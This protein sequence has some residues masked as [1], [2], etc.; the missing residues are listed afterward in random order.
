MPEENVEDTDTEDTEDTEEGKDT[1]VTEKEDSSSSGEKKEEDNSEAKAKDGGTDKAAKE[2]SKAPEKYDDFKMPEDFKVNEK[3]IGDFQPLAK[4]L[5]LTQ[6]NAQK[7]ID[8]WTKTQSETA[9][10]WDEASE[11]LDNEWAEKCRTDAEFGGQKFEGSQKNAG[12][13]IDQ[14]KDPELGKALDETRA[15]N[16]PSVFRLL[17]ILGGMMREDGLKVG[18]AMKG[19]TEPKTLAETIYPNQ[20]KE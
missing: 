3:A 6:E 7:L 20:G 10:E 8:L 12:Y 15:G 9:S 11:T 13:F 14:Y 18:N 16:H 4:E 5:G 2:E 19:S 17:A 1:I